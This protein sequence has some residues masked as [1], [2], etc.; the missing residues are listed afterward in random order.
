M[1][2]GGSACRP[3]P[4]G[5]RAPFWQHIRLLWLGCSDGAG[6]IQPPTSVGCKA[7]LVCPILP[8]TLLTWTW[9]GTSQD[10]WGRGCRHVSIP[11]CFPK[12]L[13]RETLPWSQ[14]LVPCCPRAGPGLAPRLLS[15]S[16]LASIDKLIFRM[17]LWGPITL[18]CLSC[19][20]SPKPLEPAAIPAWL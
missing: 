15:Q 17:W 4:G 2:V 7:K 5:K 20:P 9:S 16:F 1:G 11:W 13:Q 18:W 8:P 12:G 14:E 6:P 10:G 3:F 19:P